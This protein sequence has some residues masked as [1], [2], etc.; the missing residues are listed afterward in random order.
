MHSCASLVFSGALASSPPCIA[1][2]ASCSVA[3]PSGSA[4]L[5]AGVSPAIFSSSSSSFSRSSLLSSRAR[6][7]VVDVLGP[8]GL[9][10]CGRQ[11]RDGAQETA[12][13]RERREG[14]SSAASSPSSRQGRSGRAQRLSPT[15]SLLSFQSPRSSMGRMRWRGRGDGGV[16]QL[17]S[18]SACSTA[19]AE[20]VGKADLP[21]EQT[22]KK[23]HPCLYFP[24]LIGYCRLGLTVLMFNFWYSRPLLFAPLYILNF[25]LDFFDG[26]TARWRGEVTDFGTILDVITDNMVRHLLWMRLFPEVLGPFF[27][28]TEWM[29][30]SFTAAERSGWKQ[31]CFD[32][33]PPLI[34]ATMTNHF[35]TPLGSLTILGLMFL[36]LWLYVRAFED[37]L[38]TQLAALLGGLPVGMQTAAMALFRV[39]AHRGAGTILIFG[40]L[41]AF[42]CEAYVFF[43]FLLAVVEKDLETQREG[44]KKR[45]ASESCEAGELRLVPAKFE[46][47]GRATAIV[48]NRKGDERETEEEGKV[49]DSSPSPTS[50]FSPSPYPPR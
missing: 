42:M 28:F 25:V 3:G 6:L 35:R 46:E 24:N 36:P 14:V 47:L 34:Q 20:S 31:K 33:A 48:G 27:V 18:H 16:S 30:F 8:S 29:V 9:R 43:N 10:L 45:G 22:K 21:S 44:K 11:E 23:L 26:M 15:W 41:L 13:G 1:S 5:T 37:I 2:P 7:G 12:G 19:T 49:T 50:S 32:R 17:N 39:A 40:R 38:S 4:F